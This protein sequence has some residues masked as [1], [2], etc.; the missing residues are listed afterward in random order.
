MVAGEGG[1][2]LIEPPSE[3]LHSILGGKIGGEIA[4]QAGEVPLR[5]D[6]RRLAHDD[7]AWAESLD[8]E[9]ERS[10]LPGV[11]VDEGRRIRLEVDDERVQQRLPLD[12]LPLALAFQFLVDDALMRRVLV[13]DDDFVRRLGD[14]VAVVHLR[15]RRPERRGQVALGGRRRRARRCWNKCGKA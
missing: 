13:N 12:A 10:E 3:A 14:D 8:E 15:P 1:E 9:T 4:N 5:D 11:R 6:R 2:P 7:R